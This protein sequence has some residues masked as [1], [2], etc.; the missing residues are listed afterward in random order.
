MSYFK[1]SQ[2][3]I[4]T[5]CIASML[6][7]AC[8][9]DSKDIEPTPHPELIGTMVQIPAGQFIRG[10]KAGISME[11][12]MDTI[13]LDKAFTMGATEVTN[14]EFCEFLNQ[15][16]VD[17]SGKMVTARNGLQALLCASDTARSGRF[18]Q[19]MIHNGS[20][21]QPVAGFEYY[22]AIYISWYGADEYCRWNG[23]RLPTEAEWEYAAG[24][25]KLDPD[26]YAGTN[27][28]SKLGEYAWYNENSNGQS[29]PVGNK[30]PNEIGLYDMMG[31]VNEWCS[32]WF[33]KDYY[34]TSSDS[35]WF[36]NPQGPD[37]ITVVYN[38]YNFATQSYNKDYYPYITGARKVFRGGSYVEPQ[39]SG[40]EGTHRVAYR[41]HM[42]PNQVWNSYGFRFVKDL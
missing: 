5:L 28:F 13:T 1:T 23:G 10:S 36:V 31:N 37:S 14:L 22:P 15:M 24:G 16:G 41:G 42:L 27:T 7:Y 9:K 35:A 33:G 3:I 2:T 25:A 19:G 17:A 26:K 30:K 40:T 12:P 4:T 38:T 34:Q 39:T 8:K 18:N 32:D 20:T 6:L 29:K 11:R 21:W